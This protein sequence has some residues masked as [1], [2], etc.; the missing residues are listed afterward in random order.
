MKKKIPK[1][2]FITA[3]IR[4]KQVNYQLKQISNDKN[5]LLIQLKRLNVLS[6]LL[7]TIGGASASSVGNFRMTEVFII[8]WIVATLLF[9]SMLAYSM[10]S[11]YICWQINANFGLESKPISM[12][13]IN[14]VTLLSMILFLVFIVTSAYLVGLEQFMDNTFRLHWPENNQAFKFYITAAALEWIGINSISLYYLCLANRIKTFQN[15][16]LVSF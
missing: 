8:H 6:A 12:I 10:L 9:T 3:W 11:T 15:W 16:N 2:V 7:A 4:Y 13:L 14:I 1:S 5:Y